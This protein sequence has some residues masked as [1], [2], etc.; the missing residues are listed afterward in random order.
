M[1]VQVGIIAPGVFLLPW[2]A[3]LEWVFS[4]FLVVISVALVVIFILKVIPLF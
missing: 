2:V 3:G 4:S 1:D